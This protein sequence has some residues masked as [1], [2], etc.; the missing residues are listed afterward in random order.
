[1]NKTELAEIIESN[2]NIC[3]SK[4]ST[5]YDATPTLVFCPNHNINPSEAIKVYEKNFGTPPANFLDTIIST[6]PNKEKRIAKFEKANTFADKIIAVA[7]GTEN[8]TED[9]KNDILFFATGPRALILLG[10][11]CY[12]LNI[13]AG[14]AFDN[15][16]TISYPSSRIVIKVVLSKIQR[17]DKPAVAEAPATGKKQFVIT[18]ETRSALLKNLRKVISQQ[19]STIPEK[20]RHSNETSCSIYV[21]VAAKTADIKEYSGLYDAYFPYVHKPQFLQIFRSV[22]VPYQL[23]RRDKEMSKIKTCAS[24]F[25]KAMCGQVPASINKLFNVTNDSITIPKSSFILFKIYSMLMPEPERDILEMFSVFSK[26]DSQECLKAIA[27]LY[28]FGPYAQDEA[29]NVST[30]TADTE[31]ELPSENDD[32]FDTSALESEILRLEEKLRRANE[33]IEDFTDAFSRN[34]AESVKEAQIQLVSRLNSDSYNNILDM[35]M[36]LRSGL[37]ELRKSKKPVPYEINILPSLISQ[38]LNFVRDCDVSP[39][40]R[41]TGEITNFTI[42]DTEDYIYTGSP[43]SSDDEVKKVKILTSGWKRDSDGVILSLP[44]ITEVDE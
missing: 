37:S 11:L 24:L 3:L 9:Y 29:E 13:K 30:E 2:I 15:L 12:K 35:L 44:K 7:T 25:L 8:M 19:Y 31:E 39:I 14:E 27:E 10:V 40:I 33:T 1:M 20:Q 17:T 43:F 36:N 32:G 5:L 28:S 16:K 38:L 26:F 18:S 21:F 34:V 41:T 42:N 4:Q 23:E 6:F 22:Y